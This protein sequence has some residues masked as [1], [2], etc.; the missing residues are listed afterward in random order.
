MTLLARVAWIILHLHPAILNNSS[1]GVFGGCSLICSRLLKNRPVKQKWKVVVSAENSTGN[2]ICTSQ[3]ATTTLQQSE[4]IRSLWIGL[5]NRVRLRDDC[6]QNISQLVKWWRILVAASSKFYYFHF[7][8]T[9]W[10]PG[11]QSLTTDRIA[12]DTLSSPATTLKFLFNNSLITSQQ[13]VVNCTHYA[14]RYI[15]GQFILLPLETCVCH[16][17]FHCITEL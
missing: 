17:Q 7:S 3:H 11:P 16:N 4:P 2:V 1:S 14:T 15:G 6:F 9:A 5:F 12:D 10:L 8:I 13:Q